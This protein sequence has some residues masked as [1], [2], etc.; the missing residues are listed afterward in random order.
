MYMEV[1]IVLQILF[2]SLTDSNLADCEE[3]LHSSPTISYD[4]PP[5]QLYG[6]METRRDKPLPPPRMTSKP[7]SKSP[8]YELHLMSP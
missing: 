1:S 6:R 7:Q 3:A 5:S 2:V 4:I 8:R